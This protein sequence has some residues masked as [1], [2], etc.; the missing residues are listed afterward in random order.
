[1]QTAKNRLDEIEA[2]QAELRH[3][4]IDR[5]DV[6]RPRL[7]QLGL[8]ARYLARLRHEA[9]V[10]FCPHSE[11]GPYWSITRLRD[12]ESIELDT[13]TFSSD[14]F[15]GGISISSRPDDPQF[16]PSF[17]AMDPPRH[18][19][20]RRVIAPAFTPARMAS[21]APEIRGWCDEI[22][23]ALPIGVPFDWVDRVSVEL[24]ARTLASLLGFPQSHARDLIRWS[25]AMISLPGGPLFPTVEDKLRVTR[26]CFDTFDALWEYRLRDASGGDLLSMLASSADTREVD[27]AELYGNI[28]VLIVG[29]NDTTR[30]SISAS[31]VAFDSFPAELEKLRRQPELIHNLTAE[32]VRWQTPVAHMRRTA[33]RDAVVGGQKIARGDKVVLWYL[34][35]NRDEAVF[36]QAEAFLIDRA[37]A[38]RHLA[39]GAGI[40]RCVG[41]RLAE[42]Q[43]RTLWE[44]LLERVPRI[45]VVGEPRRTFSTFVNGF[46]ELQVF[47]PERRP[48]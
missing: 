6:A 16:L 46:S 19:R 9:P 17:I 26:E 37:N 23:D 31:V 10:H 4:P 18:G 45:E 44:G 34:S 47:V 1:M 24:T 28:Q 29:G 12:I 5:I 8:A 7:F 20:Q 21:L 27:R 40:H 11:Y 42:L 32:I 3:L 30:N 36:D 41:A 39:F 33:T 48:S 22:I 14:H 38:R 25:Q 35:A 15:N 2:F 43:V 13:D